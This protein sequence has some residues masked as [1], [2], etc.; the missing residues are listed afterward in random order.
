ME[1]TGAARAPEKLGPKWYTDFR[2]RKFLKGNGGHFIDFLATVL[3]LGAMAVT[4]PYAMDAAL[5]PFAIYM[6][7]WTC[8]SIIMG[9]QVERQNLS[10]AIFTNWVFM[11]WS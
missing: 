9:R 3:I 6:A 5:I 1:T 11:D 7:G 10:A 2:E 4:F 8:L